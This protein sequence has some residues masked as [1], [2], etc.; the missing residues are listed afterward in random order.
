VPRT[1]PLLDL[2]RAGDG[3]LA[4]YGSAAAPAD[5]V[6]LVEAFDPV[7]I[8]Y[9]AIRTHAAVFDV[10]HR[11][12][13]A[14]TGPD[15]LSFLN[16]MLT[17]DLSEKSGYATWTA[18]RS[19]WLNRKGRIDAD[20]RVLNL[21]DRV[22]FD[23]DVHAAERTRAGLEAYIITED[24]R[25]EDQTAQWH[26]LSV[27]GPAAA[28]LL[29]R[30]ARHSVAA[31][32]TSDALASIAPGQAIQTT[33]AGVEVVID[34]HDL[35]GE[36][37]LHLLIPASGARAV[38]EAIS[39][40]WPAAS[41]TRRPVQPSG[42]LARR[43]GWHA[44]NIARLEAGSALYLADFGPDSLPHETGAETLNDRVSFK[45]GCYLGQE[46]VARMQSLGHPKQRL[47]GL[48]IELPTDNLKPDAMGLPDLPQAVTGT[49]IVA[50]DD[51]TAPTVGAVTSSCLS[52]MRSQAHI[53]FA[54]VKWSHAQ[55]G[56]KVWAQLDD[57]RLA[58]TVHESLVCWKR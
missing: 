19:F 55:E 51:P 48:R 47:V 56:T 11:A 44:L 1:S 41:N 26:R 52:P 17:Q 2:H 27:H 18:R 36:I 13:L 5:E 29:A 15:R 32:S 38:Y 50:A 20:L 45:K 21:P 6:L 43:I 3:L 4:P 42:P 57:R 39:E 37:G 58:V 31:S 8:E 30:V 7:A 10:P 33:I 34:R 28:A 23:V 25:V 35:C 40:P 16:R 46:V 9:A 14:V 22:L 49:P 24:C 54:M 53:A 12:T